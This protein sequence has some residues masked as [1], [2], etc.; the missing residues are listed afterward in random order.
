MRT[1]GCSIQSPVKGC[2]NPCRSSYDF[3]HWRTFYVVE[4]ECFHFEPKWKPVLSRW[5]GWRGLSQL[6]EVHLAFD[7]SKQL[8]GD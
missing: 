1:H 2:V 6:T 4:R 8:V 7:L 5:E 3:S